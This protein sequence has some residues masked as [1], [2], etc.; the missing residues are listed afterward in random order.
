MADSNTT[1]IPL[2]DIDAP[3]DAE[4]IG[5]SPTFNAGYGNNVQDG[6]FMDDDKIGRSIH[7]RIQVPNYMDTDSGEPGSVFYYDPSDSDDL[8]DRKARLDNPGRWKRREK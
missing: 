7:G 1:P 5:A 8:P 3:I 6:A 4:H 2:G